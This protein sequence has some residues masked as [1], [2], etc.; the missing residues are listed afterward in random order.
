MSR[1]RVLDVDDVFNFKSF[2]YNDS[3]LD[4]EYNVNYPTGQELGTYLN[5]WPLFGLKREAAE[6]ERV[7][8][9]KKAVKMLSD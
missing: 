1:K 9:F 7:K 3:V 4:A 8:R 2:D 5:R 6:K